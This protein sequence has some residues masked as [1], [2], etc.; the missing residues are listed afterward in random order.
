MGSSG[1]AASEQT[2]QTKGWVF[3]GEFSK[4]ME[5]VKK[6]EKWLKN[7]RSFM[8]VMGTGATLSLLYD[9]FRMDSKRQ[10]WKLVN[11]EEEFRGIFE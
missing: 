8:L 7:G 6:W 2:V 11:K 9:I 1:K 4:P 3:R 10:H 5:V